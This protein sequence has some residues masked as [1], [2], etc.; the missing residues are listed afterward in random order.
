MKQPIQLNL[1]IE[2]Y[3]TE[4]VLGRRYVN[5]TTNPA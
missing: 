3:P 2:L 5:E 4:Y 1:R